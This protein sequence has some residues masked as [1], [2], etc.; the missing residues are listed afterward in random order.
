MKVHIICIMLLKVRLVLSSAT[1][2]EDCALPCYR[3]TSTGLRLSSSKL[4]ECLR[5]HCG[6]SFSLRSIYHEHELT[7]EKKLEERA[8]MTDFHPSFPGFDLGKCK[9]NC[10]SGDFQGEDKDECVAACCNTQCSITRGD[11]TT[12]I[13][14]CRA[15]DDNGS[16]NRNGNG[17][18]GNSGVCQSSCV[19]HGGSDD[20]VGCCESS[21]GSVNEMNLNDCV[22]EN[23]RDYTD[24]RCNYDDIHNIEDEE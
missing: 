20:C 21:C 15:E 1:M 4:E 10:N 12:C 13:T 23:C 2:E 17:N 18:N 3:I 8:D 24:W 7:S 6:D 9:S 14:N 5:T 16:T 19:R 11:K 22:C